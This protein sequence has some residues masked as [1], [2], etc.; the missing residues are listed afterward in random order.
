VL[1]IADESRAREYKRKYGV[2]PRS[3]GGLLGIIGG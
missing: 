3:A 1:A 2:D